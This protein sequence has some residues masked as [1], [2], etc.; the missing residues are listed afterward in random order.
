MRPVSADPGSTS[1]DAIETAQAYR[2]RAAELRAVAATYEHE[3]SR[4]DLL[5]V[6]ENCERMADR[7]ERRQQKDGD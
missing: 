2:E 7:I 6:A 5:M 4:R 1:G 3:G